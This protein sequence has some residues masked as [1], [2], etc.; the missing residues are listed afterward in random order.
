MNYIR[1]KD[2]TAFVKKEF[3]AHPE[4]F[5]ADFLKYSRKSD[6]MINGI[7]WDR[8]APKFFT[9]EDMARDDFKIQVI[10]DVTCD[11]APESSI[12]STIRATTIADPIFGFNQKTG[13]E[14]TPHTP[15]VIDVMSV[16]NLPNELPRDASRGFGKMFIQHVLGKLPELNTNPFMV[17]ATIAKNGRIG[18]HFKYLEDWIY[19]KLSK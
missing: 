2:G 7:F 13:K 11:I 10:A 1:R 15:N 5:K 17:R 16:D 12:P 18:G 6:I 9:I 19:E 4:K 14:E 8:K 3:Y